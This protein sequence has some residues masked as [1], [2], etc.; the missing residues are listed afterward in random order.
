MIQ[1]SASRSRRLGLPGVAHGDRLGAT[2]G[3]RLDDEYHWF[4]SVA[5]GGMQAIDAVAVGPGGTWAI[6]NGGE[7]GRFAHRNGHWYLAG[8]D[9]EALERGT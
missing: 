5:P 3:R 1:H 9:R 7:R 8:W 2:L 6:T 4:R